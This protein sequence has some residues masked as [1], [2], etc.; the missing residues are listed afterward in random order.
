MSN[1][2]GESLLNL[3]CGTDILGDVVPGSRKAEFKRVGTQ[4]MRRLAAGL[5]CSRREYDVRFNAGG[6]GVSG[7]LVLHTETLYVSIAQRPGIVAETR[8]FMARMCANRRDFVGGPNVWLSI[9]Y[10]ADIDTLAHDL[11]RL[12][13]AVPS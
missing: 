8:Q 11:P 2:V 13:R 12:L 3:L 9:A 5:G 7:D 10:L 4:F 6:S 1:N